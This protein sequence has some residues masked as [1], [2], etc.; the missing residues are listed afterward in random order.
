M[1]HQDD[2]EHTTAGLWAKL[3][4]RGVPFEGLV[5]TTTDGRS[6]HQT[7]RPPATAR[8]RQ[9]EARAAAAV[10]GCRYATLRDNRGR[11]FPNGQ[12]V[13]DNRTRGAVWKLIRDFNPDVLF[14]P[15]RP[16]DPSA[17]CHNDHVITATLV[18]S[19]AYQ[20]QVPHAFPQYEYGTEKKSMTPPLIIGSYDDYLR[21]RAWDIAVDIAAVFDRKVEA[22]D[23]HRSQL[24]EWLPWVGKYPAPRNRADVAAW[25]RK[26]HRAINREA[27]LRTSRPHEF[28]FVTR[29][30]RGVTRRDL[31]TFFPG[32]RV[33][34]HAR[35]L[36]G[37]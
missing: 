2:W 34:P 37:R 27:R 1:A 19:V 5:V 31:G 29:W 14:C 20:V 24:Y 32:G 13:A 10:L 4:A 36:I 33:A 6:G 21:G 12:L 15:P 28:F 17:G 25:L 3:R 18:W 8:R 26:R 23:R 35:R 9:A 16:D 30:G 22:L 7:M 11:A